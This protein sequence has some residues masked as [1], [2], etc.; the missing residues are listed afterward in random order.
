MRNF[1]RCKQLAFLSKGCMYMYM[2][3]PVSH[4]LL[5]DSLRDNEVAYYILETL[6]VSQALS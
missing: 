1:S 3:N 2:K 5:N 4:Y 6:G